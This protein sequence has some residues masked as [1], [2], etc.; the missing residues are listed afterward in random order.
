V[1]FFS[2]L[3]RCQRGEMNIL[4]ALIVA[5]LGGTVT[6]GIAGAM[7]A[8]HTSTKTVTVLQAGPQQGSNAVGGWSVVYQK[9]SPSI[10]DITVQSTK[11]LNTFIG[12]QTQQATQ[13]GSGFVIDHQGHILTAAHVIAGATSITVTFQDGTTRPAKALGVDNSADVAMLQVSP[14]G[15]GLKPLPLGNDKALVIGDPIAAIGDPLG[16]DRSLSTGVVSALGRTIN[17]PDGFPITNAIQTDAALNPGNSGGPIINTSGQVI[18]IADQIVTGAN[19]LSGTSGSDTNTGVGLAVP[20]DLPR[21]ELSRL[22]GNQQLKHAYLGIQ[23]ASGPKPGALVQSVQSGTPAASAGLR[24][25]DLIIAFNG[26][27]VK[28]PNSLINLLGTTNAGAKAILTVQRGPKTLTFA[29]TL[30]SQP[31]QAPSA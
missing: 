27:P 14:S 29:L 9:D 22:E 30:A 12:P 28:D 13:L 26:S 8:L 25:G 7:G 31:S 2:N 6:L 19:Q 3:M 21:A 17:A 18:G 10:V 4:T 11:S 20:I 5:I 23:T 24:A 15:L 1:K 16:L